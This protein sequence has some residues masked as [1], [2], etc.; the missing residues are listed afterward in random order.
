MTRSAVLAAIYLDGGG[1]ATETD[2]ICRELD[3]VGQTA[4]KDDAQICVSRFVIEPS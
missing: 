4:L 3:V 2:R 1:V